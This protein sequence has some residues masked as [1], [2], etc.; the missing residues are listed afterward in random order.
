[1][2]FGYEFDDDA[3]TSEDLNCTCMYDDF[4]YDSD[5]VCKFRS[6]KNVL[7]HEILCISLKKN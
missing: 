3:Y 4:A 2:K 1:M 7:I 5:S 6:F